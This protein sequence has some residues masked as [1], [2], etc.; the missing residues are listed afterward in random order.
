MPD[1]LEKPRVQNRAGAEFENVVAIWKR[2]EV[3]LRLE[4]YGRDLNT[5]SVS[6]VTDWGTE[7]LKKRR[8]QEGKKAAGDI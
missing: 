5:S 1:S 7:E 3:S 2:G 4:K 6:Y 8:G